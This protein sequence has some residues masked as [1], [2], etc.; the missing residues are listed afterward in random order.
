MASALTKRERQAHDR[1]LKLSAEPTDGTPE[2]PT[3]QVFVFYSLPGLGYLTKRECTTLEQV[4]R[5]VL[6]ASPQLAVE[7]SQRHLA[8]SLARFAQWFLKLD[9]D[10]QVPPEVEYY[11]VD[12]SSTAS[13]QVEHNTVDA[14]STASAPTQLELPKKP[15]VHPWVPWTLRALYFQ[16]LCTSSSTVGHHTAAEAAEWAESVERHVYDACVGPH[17]PFVDLGITVSEINLMRREYSQRLEA[18]VDTL[19]QSSEDVLRHPPAIL[20][21]LDT[22]YLARDLP[23]TRHLASQRET[24]RARKEMLLVETEEIGEKLKRVITAP[25]EAHTEVRCRNPACR[26][27][28]IHFYEVQKRSADEP[29]T[30]F[31]QCNVCQRQWVR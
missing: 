13:T 24:F 2:T 4:A 16:R 31:Y 21:L 19:V 6:E 17:D 15:A 26:S 12:A 10:K 8:G 9:V 7:F 1:L 11:T 18:I 30:V 22:E 5:C 28:D 23:I 27:T 3:D 29:M 20:S 14:S 25:E